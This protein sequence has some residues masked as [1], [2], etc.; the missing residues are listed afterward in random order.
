MYD[1]LFIFS[2]ETTYG[3]P[4]FIH[5]YVDHILPVKYF[6]KLIWI[7]FLYFAHRQNMYLQSLLTSTIIAIKSQL[8]FVS[9]GAWNQ[10]L[11]N[12]SSS[13]CSPSVCRG[14]TVKKRLEFIIICHTLSF[15][16][17]VSST[18]RCYYYNYITFEICFLL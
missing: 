8:K 13:N 9:A 4:W 16:V 6:N 14:R 15:E 3:P 5:V 17:V 12:N 1:A 7:G 18:E 10:I 2:Y 11:A